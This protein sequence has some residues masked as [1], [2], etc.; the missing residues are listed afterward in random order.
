MRIVFD[1]PLSVEQTQIA[2]DESRYSYGIKLPKVSYLTMEG[3]TS[4]AD[5]ET[6]ARECQPSSM[7]TPVDTDWG[8]QDSLANIPRKKVPSWIRAL[9]LK[10]NE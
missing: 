3:D 10:D 1:R 9:S 7:F 8:E 2:V 6:E 4:A 5:R